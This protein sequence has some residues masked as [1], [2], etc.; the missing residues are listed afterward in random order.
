VA[1]DPDTP[2]GWADGDVAR[3]AA[4]A[5]LRR[6]RETAVEDPTARL[7]QT[8]AAIDGM[9]DRMLAGRLP[10]PNAPSSKAVN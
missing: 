9:R 3:E 10:E 1:D 4:E 7:R 6:H 5:V 8:L 2:G